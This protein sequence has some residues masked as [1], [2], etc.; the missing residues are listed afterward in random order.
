MMI[1][2]QQRNSG[3]VSDAAGFASRRPMALHSDTNYFGD[4]TYHFLSTAVFGCT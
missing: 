3:S 2:I 1:F 4:H